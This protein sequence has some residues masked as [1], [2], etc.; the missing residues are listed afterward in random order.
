MEY[1]ASRREYFRMKLRLVVTLLAVSIAAA[2]C[3]GE[4]PAPVTT[5]EI[6]LL[7]VRNHSFFEVNVFALPSPVSQTR[8]RLGSV[9]SFTDAQLRVPRIA[10]RQNGSLALLLHAIGSTSSWQSPEVAVYPGVVP[11]LDIHATLSG[12]LNRSVFYSKLAPED[13]TGS[14]PATC[15]FHGLGSLGQVFRYAHR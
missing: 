15:G 11:C 10:L 5:E 6:V 4:R 7:D 14:R 8:I 13:T 9:L 3:R 2:A 1:G 12:D